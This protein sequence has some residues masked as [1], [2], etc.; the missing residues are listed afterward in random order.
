MVLL[1]H[2]LIDGTHNMFL[3]ADFSKLSLHF[4]SYIIMKLTFLRRK[5]CRGYKMGS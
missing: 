2:S 1:L 3:F 5:I 4:F